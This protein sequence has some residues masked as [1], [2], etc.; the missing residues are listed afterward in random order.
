MRGGEQVRAIIARRVLGSR[1]RVLGTFWRW[2]NSI[3]RL[4]LD[5]YATLTFFAVSPVYNLCLSSKTF[6]RA[7][8]A[9]DSTA[10]C[11]NLCHWWANYWQPPRNNK[12]LIPMA[13]SPLRQD[14][15]LKQC[16]TSHKPPHLHQT[17]RLSSKALE[18]NQILCP[19]STCQILNDSVHISI[20]PWLWMATAFERRIPCM[21]KWNVQIV[22]TWNVS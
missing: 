20:G 12:V 1:G 13:V 6:F 21:H 5:V 18:G 11:I 15:M 3:W 19:S 10:S 17:R 14:E 9:D 2:G 16:S 8:D 7:P 22:L 4:I